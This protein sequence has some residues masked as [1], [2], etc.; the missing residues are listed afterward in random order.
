[1][2]SSSLPS[3][4]SWDQLNEETLAGKSSR[5]NFKELTESAVPELTSST[6]DETALVFLK[7][8]GS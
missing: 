1:M 8:Q 2:S 6:V 3:I 7:M 5:R 4:R